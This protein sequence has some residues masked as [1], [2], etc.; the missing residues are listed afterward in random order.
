M[1]INL[2]QL[3]AFRAVII[4]GSI[5]GAASYL[6]VSQ[7]AVSRLI[8]DLEH[9]IGFALFERRNRRLHVKPEGEIFYR[10]RKSTRLNSSH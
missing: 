9:S 2:R 3:E 5:T 7:P 10:D 6:H 8:A 1:A 4:T